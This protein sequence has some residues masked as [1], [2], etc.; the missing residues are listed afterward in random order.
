VRKSDVPKRGALLRGDRHTERA[1][2]HVARPVTQAGY[3]HRMGADTSSRGLA[4]ANTQA[5][6]TPEQVMRSL[7]EPQQS[8]FPDYGFSEDT[9]TWA[10]WL[11]FEDRERGR[12]FMNAL[13]NNLRLAMSEI[14]VEIEHMKRDELERREVV[15]DLPNLET[16]QE[17]RVDR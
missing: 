14:H 13:L 6:P 17:E 3:T 11:F 9:L 12:M 4:T 5:R 10:A 1:E 7:E 8:E 2:T 16:K 15:I